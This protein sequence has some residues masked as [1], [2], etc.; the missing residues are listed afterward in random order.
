MTMESPISGNPVLETDRVRLRKITSADVPAIYKYCSDNEVARYTSWHAHITQADTEGFVHHILQLYADQRLAPWGIEDKETG[1]IIGTVGFVYVDPKH[2]RAEVA[3]ALSRHDW[4]K[5]IMS[6]VVA[7]VLAYAFDVLRL[8]RV[9]A[10]CL[11]PNTGSARVMEKCGMAFEGILR[12]HLLVKGKFEDLKTYA[13]VHDDNL[14][15]LQ[16]LP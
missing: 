10:R 13:I 1:T 9:E 11:V 16:G 6:E 2:A 3:Y 7:R 14:K 8:V 4:N 5:G 12:K 15:R